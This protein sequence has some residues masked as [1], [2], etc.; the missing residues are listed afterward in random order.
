MARRSTQLFI[1]RLPLEA[2]Q[3]DLEN[4]FLNY[5]RM[6]RCDIRYGKFLSP[7]L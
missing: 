4:V 7:I 5:G 1:G 2:K 6:L 3:R